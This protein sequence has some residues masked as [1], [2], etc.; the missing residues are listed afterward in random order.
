MT[1]STL[2][3]SLGVKLTTWFTASLEDSGALKLG[4]AA[5]PTSLAFFTPFFHDTSSVPLVPSGTGVPEPSRTSRYRCSILLAA[6]TAGRIRG[7]SEGGGAEPSGGGAE[8][9]KAGGGVV[10]SH[11]CDGERLVDDARRERAREKRGPQ[12][13]GEI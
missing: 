9:E 4:R 2:A 12:C 10:G 5:G 8:K 13:G 7:V 1:A 3:P 11:A 6:R